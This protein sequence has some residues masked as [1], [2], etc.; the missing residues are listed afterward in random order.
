M[1]AGDRIQPHPVAPVPQCSCARCLVKFKRFLFFTISQIVFF[2]WLGLSGLGAEQAQ[3]GQPAEPPEKTLEELLETPVITAASK[4]TERATEA[5]S[6]VSVVTADEIKKYGYR[7]L[8]EILEGV[9]GLYVTYDRNYSYLGI[10]GFNLGDYNSRVLILV[11]GH[12][13]N[14][15]LSDGGFI[16]QEFILD[17]DL[18]EQVEV[19]RGPGSILY[20]N[21]EFFGVIEVVTRGG[22]SMRGLGL[23][24]SVEGGTFDTYQGRVTWGHQFD[25]D[26]EMLFSGSIYE[27]AGPGKLFFKEFN[28]PAMNN[29]VAEDADDE[30]SK[31]AF[32]T[33]R[34]R[35][36]V[37]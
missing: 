24:G 18:I 17:V 32:G 29:G 8:A 12:R 37:W 33:V 36:L 21:N 15:N 19:I 22:R 27:S 28:T 25:A 1:R 9:C 26:L 35:S 11:D 34:W 20:G 30:H 13:L 6:S 2:A 16:G 7:T 5:P 10:R 23:E 31:S 4:R 14:N 3:Q